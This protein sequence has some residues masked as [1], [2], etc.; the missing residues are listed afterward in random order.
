M[1]SDSVNAAQIVSIAHQSDEYRSMMPAGFLLIGAGSAA[2]RT[3]S[4]DVKTGRRSTTL[5]A[6]STHLVLVESI[7]RRVTCGSKGAVRGSLPAALDA[8]PVGA[9]PRHGPG[10]PARLA[11]HRGRGRDRG[12]TLEALDVE[13]ATASGVSEHDGGAGRP[14]LRPRSGLRA[15]LSRPRGRSRPGGAGATRRGRRGPAGRPARPGP[16]SRGTRARGR[17]G[18]G[19]WAPGVGAGGTG[20]R[21]RWR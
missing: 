14:R 21:R 11:P 19:G 3:R 5:L 16:R 17:A 4:D 8:R 9:G 2:A 13:P 15:G 12:R 6:R 1:K 18:R 7:R 20:S 10:P